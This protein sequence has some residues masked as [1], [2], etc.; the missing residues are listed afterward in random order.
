MFSTRDLKHI[1][2]ATGGKLVLKP[3][4]QDAVPE[5]LSKLGFK[6]HK[7]LKH[8]D[9]LLPTYELK[10]SQCTTLCVTSRHGDKYMCYVS[11]DG[12]AIFRKT[13]AIDNIDK[14]VLQLHA[15]DGTLH[16]LSKL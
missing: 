10:L 4:K 1:A 6:L 5:T 16:S 12:E 7:G 2:Q 9:N 14:F 15:L 3:R 13:L 8:G 11:S